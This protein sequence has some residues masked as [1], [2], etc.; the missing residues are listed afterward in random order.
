MAA[1]INSVILIGNLT[2]DIDIAY[3]SAGM[4]IGTISI[5]SNKKVKRQDN[6]VDE[7][8]Y[9]DV[10]I[11]GKMAE[12]LKPYL[13]KGKKICV[14]GSLKQDRWEKDGQKNARVRIIAEQIELIGGRETSSS[15]NTSSAPSNNFVAND[16]AGPSQNFSEGEF[17]EDI[18]F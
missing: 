10:T 3:T 5:A 1:D 15:E 6:W 9:F 4:A 14:Q 11:F 7:V 13:L 12:G 8:S 17:Q 18:P 2:R 16:M